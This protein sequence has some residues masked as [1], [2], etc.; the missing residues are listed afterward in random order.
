MKR[1]VIVGVVGLAFAATAAFLW[2][3]SSAA[4]SPEIATDSRKEADVAPVPATSSAATSRA[5]SIRAALPPRGLAVTVVDPRGEAVVGAPVAFAVRRP[6]EPVDRWIELGR[7]TAPHGKLELADAS[8]RIAALRDEWGRDSSVGI[9]LYVPGVPSAVVPLEPE[10]LPAEGVRLVASGCGS[11]VARILDA[12]GIEVRAAITVQLNVVDL[13]SRGERSTKK[14]EVDFDTGVARFAAVPLKRRLQASVELRD[15]RLDA[16]T[17]AG[18]ERDGEVVEIVWR[19][20]SSHPILTGTCI[21]E[22]A[23]VVPRMPLCYSSSS[24][25]TPWIV[26]FGRADAVGR[27]RLVLP[28]TL[29]GKALRDL[30]FREGSLG[31]PAGRGGKR[32]GMLDLVPGVTDLGTVSFT[33]LP[34]LLSVVAMDASG[35]PLELYAWYRGL[36]LPGSNSLTA[37]SFHAPLVRET[38]PGHVEFLGV[39]DSV[40]LELLVGSQLPNAGKPSR[41]PVQV[42]A[43]DVRIVATAFGSLAASLRGAEGMAARHELV[44]EGKSDSR[45]FPSLGDGRFT[46]LEPGL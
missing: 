45:P 30:E 24:V 8:E 25:Q 19:L 38:A 21:G 32:P 1:S 18:P 5:T 9:A 28:S 10:T 4:H 17:V 2:R 37:R 14:L 26:G 29:A 39:A 34:I 36:G 35:Q 41:V 13:R 44:I 7:T 11:V 43:R 3:G 40:S 33:R 31:K 20:P 15:F 22:D 46:A 6:N 23:T 27:F 42:G 16:Q 12:D